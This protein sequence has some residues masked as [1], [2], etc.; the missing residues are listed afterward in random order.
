MAVLRTGADE[1]IYL[2]A[3]RDVV[4]HR[5][6]AIL[7]QNLL[8]LYLQLSRGMAPQLLATVRTRTELMEDSSTSVILRRCWPFPQSS[9]GAASDSRVLRPVNNS[10]EGV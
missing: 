6:L 1:E 4:D 7:F 10:I 5:G 3:A 9:G 8:R 2:L